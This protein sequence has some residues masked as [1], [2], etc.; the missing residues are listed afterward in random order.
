MGGCHHSEAEAR[1]DY[2]GGGGVYL[3]GPAYS[4]DGAEDVGCDWKVHVV[5]NP[6]IV[7]IIFY[8]SAHR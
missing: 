1:W 5:V 7:S 2:G 8:K 4:T 3:N 6:N